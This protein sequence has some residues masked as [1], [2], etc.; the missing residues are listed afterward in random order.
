MKGGTRVA[1]SSRAWRTA[2]YARRLF[3]SQDSE[4]KSRHLNGTEVR[5]YPAVR[6]EVAPHKLEPRQQSVFTRNP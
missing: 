2:K 4:K 3:M 6:E 1:F 5:Y